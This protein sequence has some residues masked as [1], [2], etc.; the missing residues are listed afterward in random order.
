MLARPVYVAGAVRSA[1]GRR[2]GVLAGV[3]PADLGGAVVAELLERTGAAGDAAAEVD[4]VILGCV[5]QLGAQ[6]T[7]LARIVALSAGLPESVP[8]TTIDRQCGSSQQALNFGVQAIASGDQDLVVAGGV[9]VMSRIPIASA[10]FVGAEHGMGLPRDGELWRKRYGDEEISQFRGAQLIADHWSVSR[11]R[12][13]EF[14]L[15][16]HARALAARDGGLFDAEIAPVYG[17]ARDEGPRADTTAEKMA[18]LK[19]L[20]EGGTLTAAVASQIS[21]GAA[22]LLLASETAVERH[23]LT[24]LARVVAQTVV[25]SDPVM[26]LTGPI[27]ATAR[28]LAKAGLSAGD[29]DFFEVNEAFASVVLAWQHETGVGA[30]RTNVLG[31]AISLGHPLGATGARLATTLVHHLHRTGARYGLQV[32]CEGGGMANATILERV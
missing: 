24:P 12:M 8:G 20:A 6:S 10:A 15:A 19:P 22:V 28:V 2:R 7:N 1:I 23:G 30:D 25:G 31:G 27:P 26:M 17:L 29:I 14:A 13:E 32:M 11:E 21:D 5:T 16:S 4:D 18:A 9:E 3:H